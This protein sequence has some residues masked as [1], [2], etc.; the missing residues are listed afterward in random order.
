M[1]RHLTRMIIRKKA[2]E[3]NHKILFSSVRTGKYYN[4]RPALARTGECLFVHFWGSGRRPPG[5]PPA[6]T[7]PHAT[8]RDTWPQPCPWLW[9]GQSWLKSWLWHARAVRPRVALSSSLAWCPRL[10][11]ADNASTCL[12]GFLRRLSESML[13]KHLESHPARGGCRHVWDHCLLVWLFFAFAI[14]HPTEILIHVHREAWKRV[15]TETFFI[16]KH[17]RKSKEHE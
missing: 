16:I 5:E 1:K 7:C 15:M 14:M 13:G 6:S 9:S 4:N 17:P 10:E 8:C 2:N 11:N 12:P 3:N